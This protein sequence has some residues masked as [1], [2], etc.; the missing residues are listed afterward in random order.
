MRPGFTV[1]R[2]RL[3]D[4]LRSPDMSRRVLSALVLCALAGPVAAQGLGEAAR[5]EG[6][7]RSRARGVTKS[8]TGEDLTGGASTT[9]PAAEPAA[10][11]ATAAPARPERDPARS[12]PDESAARA[13]EEVRWR[14]SVQGL[15]QNVGILE[16]AAE[17]ADKAATWSAYAGPMSC[18]GRV[19]T[20]HERNVTELQEARQ[21]L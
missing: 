15:R 7:R 18:S 9:A 21:A 16:R 12:I 13:R 6:E 8:Y 10:E 4:G 2:R 3:Y 14:R 20:R 11:A 19:N 5:K 17:Q 1:I